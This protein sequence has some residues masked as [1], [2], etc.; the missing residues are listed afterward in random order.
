MSTTANLGHTA[1]D[2]PMR[3][4]AGKRLILPILA[5]AA[6]ALLPAAARAQFVWT[7]GDLVTAIGTNV[8]GSAGTLSITT[9]VDHDFPG[10]AF[11]N[12]GT[13]AWND[14]NLRSGGGGSL[15]NNGTFNDN[16][17]N[18]VLNNDF[19]GTMSTVTN[20]GT[21]NKTAAG[22]ELFF[23]PFTQSGQYNLQAGTTE[24]L[25]G[26][27]LGPTSTTTL[28]SG[29][30]FYFNGAY[31]IA[32]GA[33][34]AGPG[35]FQL[36][37][38]TLTVA[39]IL[40]APN[41]LQTNGLLAGAPVITGAYEWQA[42][43]WNSGGTTTIGPTGVL[44]IT[45]GVDHDYAGT[46]IVNNGTINW[47]SGNLRSGGAGSLINNGTFNDNANNRLFNNDYNGA[48]STVANNG[49]WNK[50]AAGYELFFVP[51]TQ[52]G[53]YNLQA[54]TTEVLG[55]GSLGPTST[56]TV[57]SGTTFYFNGAY[58][59]AAGA[60][61]AGPGTFQLYS[62]TLT[63]AGI[64]NAPNFLQTN[65]LL[66][67]A[68][69]ITGAY[70]WQAG[71]WNSGGTTTIGPT[72]VLSIT[73]GVDHDYAGTAIVNNGTINWSSGNLRSGGAGS[74]INNGTFNDN[75]NNRLFNNDYNGA[76]STVANN[77]TWNKTAAGYE[78]FYVP[79]TQSGLYNLQAG[80]TE[81]LAGGSLGPGSVTTASL[82]TTF[83]FNSNYSI[84]AGASLA[85]PGTFQLYSNTLTVAGN[86]NAPNFLQTNGL[87][88][89]S[90]V[91][92][93]AYE[94]QAGTWNSGGV[95]TI[96]PSG[97]LSI[98][99]S[100][101]HDYAGTAIV[102]NGTVNWNNGNLRSGSGGSLT[103]S[104]TFND[105]ATNRVFNNDYNGAMS[106]VTNNGT[107]NKTV[108]GYEYF[109]VPFTQSGLY[110]L[111]AGTTEVL[112][113][114][115]LGPGS[116]TTASLGTTFYFNS[117]YSIAA[118]A[119]L[120]G[121]GTF[122]LYSNTLTVAGNL[123]APRF[124]QTSGLLAGTPV[125]TGGYEWQ[126]GNW[127]SGGTSTIGPT[128]V[129]DVTTGADHDYAATAIVNNG[130]VN[131]S[132]GNLRSGSGGSLTNNGIFN[133]NSNNRVFNN[134]YNGAMSSVTNTGL[135][136]KAAA[137]TT[138]MLVPY[139]NNN[140]LINVS[141]GT[142]EFAAGF[143]Q[144]SGTLS[145]SNGGTMQFD[146]GLGLGAGIIAG[147]GNIV[148]NVTS[149]AV[150][151]PGA[152]LGQLNFA[153]NLVLQGASFLV[154]DLGGTSRGT[155][156]D[157]LSVSGTTS[158]GGYLVLNFANGFRSSVTASDSFTLL[159]ASSVSGAFTNVA[160]GARISTTDGLGSFQINY[161]GGGLVTATSFVAIPEPSTWALLAAGL[162]GGT[163]IRRVRSR[164]A[165]SPR[166]SAL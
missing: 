13:V 163:V 157:S 126:S 53:Q 32:A 112:A 22:Y 65:G 26:G 24:V 34:L 89:G 99:T 160:S 70:E 84:A 25:G 137:G 36:Y 95:N 83:Y 135:W 92:T 120:A 81:V 50:T 132:G 97:V 68:P 121:P 44:S 28:S 85:G 162:V 142:F 6:A 86:L 139:V 140:G 56:T 14:G 87:L 57:S 61:L 98:T 5:A 51:F 8:I 4:A 35:T 164:R 39:G 27:S 58:S 115:S 42:G 161:G 111:Q 20:N 103:N 23:V 107:W 46:A 136:N 79:F 131:W 40:N 145:V 55:G 146:S 41:F 109:Y 76:M 11:V 105:N 123:N 19:N 69:V 116:V 117:N 119:S 29:T 91:I 47:S 106:T 48:M 149:N 3:P 62:N 102:N 93:G 78:Y 155:T 165:S 114:G 144:N 108:A 90:P 71:T 12:N 7:G 38:N 113:G 143:T 63:V 64:L 60:T 154:F 156:Y 96:G 72:G 77:G 110:N 45:T 31:S 37:S 66:A 67:G 148:G 52:S 21:W 49:T 122:Q 150:I 129:L 104:G 75:A 16:A 153:G 151:S 100:A 73:T 82:G 166:S 88:A 133:D 9:G 54:G 138:T 17:T 74:L 158:L 1:G 43:T 128:G 159:S 124:L 141:A 125:I 33:T 147:T 94:W 101:D 134:D 152:S 15:T 30:T 59:I 127:N 10:T 118:G 2:I 130:T 80:T 18:R